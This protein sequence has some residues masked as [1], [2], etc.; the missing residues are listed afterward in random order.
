MTK[1]DVNEKEQDAP[2]DGSRRSFLSKMWL[3]LGFLALA[4]YAGLAVAFLRPRKPPLEEGEFGAVMAVGSVEEFRKGTVT[5][6]PEGRFYL[7]RLE[8]GS[9]LALLR[10][11][12]HLGCTV[13]WD[14]DQNRFIC[15][16]HASSFDMAGN[17]ISPPA[18]R[19]LDLYPV[20]IENDMV[21][22]DTGKRMKRKTFLQ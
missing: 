7:V 11:C 20:F 6:F 10:E 17:V 8:D 18:P 1:K 21:K 5:A 16:C 14:A 12:T 19:G 3:G 4:E 13:P 2:Q 15:P 9:F 22:V